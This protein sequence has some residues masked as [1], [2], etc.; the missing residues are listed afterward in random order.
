MFLASKSIY[1]I[2]SMYIFY[3]WDHL[4][5]SHDSIALQTQTIV[6]K[7]P[8]NKQKLQF[9]REKMLKMKNF[10]V[11]QLFSNFFGTIF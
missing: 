7:I 1:F 10:E 6:R 3:F 5:V 9:S 2:Q 11:G 8:E 4:S